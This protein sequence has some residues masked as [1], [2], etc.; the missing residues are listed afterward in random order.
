MARLMFFRFRRYRKNILLVY[1]AFK[2]S[3][4]RSL[5]PIKISRLTGVHMLDIVRTLNNTPEIFFKVPTSESTKYALR[6]SIASQERKSVVKYIQKRAI[7][8]GFFFY[9]LVT[10]LL[11]VVLSLFFGGYPFIKQLLVGL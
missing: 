10:I 6:L 3:E 7:F 2:E 8:E 11:L 5:H 9:A 1:D 4:E